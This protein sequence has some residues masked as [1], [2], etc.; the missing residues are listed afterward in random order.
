M[1]AKERAYENALDNLTISV[2]V[3]V[4]AA[5]VVAFGLGWWFVFGN[6]LVL[7]YQAFRFAKA[8]RA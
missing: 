4:A 7:A 2:S 1:N 3:T 6:G 5:V 8:A